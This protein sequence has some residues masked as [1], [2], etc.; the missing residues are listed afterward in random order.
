MP[1][2]ISWVPFFVVVAVV[3][4]SAG[5]GSAYLYLHSKSATPAS[6]RLVQVGD[7]V[8]VNYI[9]IYGSGPETGRVFDTSL[10]TVGTNAASWP[11]SIEFHAR[12]TQPSNFTPLDVH[13]GGNTPQSG[14]SLGNLSFIQVVPGFW[15]GLVGI[16]PNQTH[17]IIVP[18]AL[19]YGYPNPT[20]QSV[21]PLTQVLPVVQT[22]PGKTFSTRYP[23]ALAASGAMFTDPHYGWT[24]LV[25]SANASFV[26]IENLAQVGDTAS[27]A[28]WTVEVTSVTSTA[29]GTG[30]IT[31]ENRL[32]P[33]QA[34]LIV[35]K[36]FQGTGP[37]SS[38]SGGKFIVTAVDPVHG[39]YTED[40]DQEVV[41]KTLI[42]LVTIVNV[43][44]GNGVG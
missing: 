37:C 7:N 36:D 22:L 4:A 3:V 9:G 16:L 19:G 14:Y 18:P 26:T 44:P 21:Q 41:G 12:G 11:K 5:A 27:P 23:S 30:A 6:P 31:L 17:T 29:N 15:Q 39:T 8:T 32:V 33:S 20:C 25:L 40:Y 42:F 1:P 43:Y 34:G 38:S 13:V 28:G 24:V 35:G 10:Y 2:R